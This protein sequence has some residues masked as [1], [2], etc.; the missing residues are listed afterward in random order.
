MVLLVLAKV[1]GKVADTFGQERDLNPRRATV[2]IVD[3]VF[4]DN[5][6]AIYRHELRSL[7]WLRPNLRS[8]LKG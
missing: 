7:V 3:L 1:L 4:A 6:F 5:G 2:F 8:A